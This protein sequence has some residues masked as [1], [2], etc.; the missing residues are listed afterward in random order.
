MTEVKILL[1]YFVFPGFISLRYRT[2]I[3]GF[4]HSSGLFSFSSSNGLA[5]HAD[6]FLLGDERAAGWRRIFCHLHPVS[7]DLSLGL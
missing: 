4:R 1:G 7:D 2:G 6:N 3:A 5:I